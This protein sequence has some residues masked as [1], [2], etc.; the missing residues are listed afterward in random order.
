VPAIGEGDGARQV[1]SDPDPLRVAVGDV[2][3]EVEA[4][5]DGADHRWIAGSPAAV[6]ITSIS[7]DEEADPGV[8]PAVD[9]P[10][11]A[12]ALAPTEGHGCLDLSGDELAA[13]TDAIERSGANADT[14]WTTRGRLFRLIVRPVHAH[15]R[16][17]STAAGPGPAQPTPTTAE[18][19]P[20]TTPPAKPT[21]STTKPPSE[22]TADGAGCVP[23]S[24]ALGNGRWFGYLTEASP[25]GVEFDLACWF[26]GRSA[27]LAAAEDGHGSPPPNDF[28]IR[29]TNP[30][31]RTLHPGAEIP[32]VWYPQIGDPGSK[33]ET[34]LAEWLDAD[35]AGAGT[36]V[37]ITISAGRVTGIAEQWTA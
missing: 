25:A 18:P 13:F 16:P 9:L 6:R 33:V 4:I 11:D 24:G 32:V 10:F 31:T 23:G 8:G 1:G 7:H 17:C 14:P 37:W 15:E 2:V 12:A 29:N 3:A 28:Y 21:T 34:T 35:R 36:G 20:K 26:S 30:A 5:V 22:A 19:T 27:V